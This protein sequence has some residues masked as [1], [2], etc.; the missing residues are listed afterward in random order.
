MPNA[1]TENRP[2]LKKYR[3]ERVNWVRV[4]CVNIAI[5]TPKMGQE[6]CMLVLL[7]FDFSI[8]LVLMREVDSSTVFGGLSRSVRPSPSQRKEGFS[9]YRTD[10]STNKNPNSGKSAL[11]ERASSILCLNEQEI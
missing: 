9:F 5:V 11:F 4:S 10:S 2:F 6:I 7:R 8:T 3:S 1:L